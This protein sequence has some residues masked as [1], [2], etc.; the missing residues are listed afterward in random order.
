MGNSFLSAVLYLE[1][2]YLQPCLHC[3]TNYE[4]NQVDCNNFF[5]I[6][7]VV[8]LTPDCAPQGRRGTWGGI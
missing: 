8:P 7:G 2:T 6:S 3:K 4:K 1:K 5:T